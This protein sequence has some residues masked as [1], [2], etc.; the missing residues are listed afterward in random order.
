[1]SWLHDSAI[2]DFTRGG[3]LAI[4]FLRMIGQVV[5]KFGRAI[6]ILYLFGT[7]ALWWNVT[8]DYERYLGYRYAG[9]KAACLMGFQA[10]P[11]TLLRPDSR[12]I[13]TTYY[14]IANSPELHQN[15]I[16][17]GIH[18]LKSMASSASI[19][20]VLLLVIFVWLFRFGRSQRKELVLRGTHMLESGDLTRHMKKLKV[21]SDL[22][23]AGIPLVFASE[24]QHIS[25]Q[26]APGTGKTTTIHELLQ[27]IRRRGDRV[28][29]FSPSGDFIEWFYRPNVDVLL[30]P[31]DDRCPSW[32][33]WDECEEAFHFDM[34]ANAMIPEPTAGDPIW[35][36]AARSL[37]SVA[38]ST[39]K[40]R[41]NE[42]IAG[43]MRLITTVPMEQICKYLQGTEVSAYLDP[44]N[45]KM[46][47][48]IRSTAA[49][50]LRSFKY[51]REDNDRFN[52]RKWVN[53]DKGSS[54]IFLN[55]KPD[56]L[57][58]VR[59]VLTTWLEVFVNSLLSLPESRQRRIWLIIDELPALNRVPSLYDFLAQARKFGG[60]GV[61]AYQQ[62]SQ[63]REKYG[64]DGAENLAGL[65]GTRVNMRSNDT[66]SATWA[67]KNFGQIEI[68]ESSQ[69]LSYGAN[70]MRDGVGLSQQRKMI[71]ILLPGEVMALD[72]LEGFIKLKG[73]VPTGHFKMT[74]TTI[75]SV[76]LPYVR[77]I[78]GVE[79][80]L[81]GILG[82][83]EGEID[84]VPEAAAV[85]AGAEA[86]ADE[87]TPTT[88]ETL[89]A[90]AA[91]AAPADDDTTPAVAATAVSTVVIPTLV[92]APKVPE[93]P[94][95][96][97]TR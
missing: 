23:V 83:E 10:E 80:M 40:N 21:A 26:G 50:Y 64:K 51:V 46:G 49:I 24:T 17:L 25:L 39:M 42:S 2:G 18:W 33:L 55:A 43:L 77:R 73:N 13:R 19:A 72:D 31:F 15:L 71:D 79:P 81:P 16:D 92:P 20:F 89:P 70:D 95:F 12:L 8:T 85:A 14:G 47:A 27:T 34:I 87:A 29:N 96:A 58:A 88:E 84:V 28:I 36:N 75:K 48:N 97:S 35:N 37:V 38:A 6:I 65:C 52:I 30:N 60:C 67:A 86:A 53:E 44:K 90:A 7:A 66:E 1:M 3:Q 59:S 11:T 41:G 9:A 22:K 32:N 57:P 5:T 45:E 62:P 78:D 94:D 76:A 91:A 61:L 54:W 56:Q 74:R 93:V 68:M 63:L 4:H 82:E 69:N